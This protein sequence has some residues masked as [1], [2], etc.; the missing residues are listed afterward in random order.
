[1]SKE[2]SNGE[3]SV[4]KLQLLRAGSLRLAVIADEIAAITEWM[5]P[6][7][8]PNAPPA[9]LGVAS[10]QG[11]ML[12]V[13]DPLVLFKEEQKSSPAHIVAL[14]GDEQLALAVGSIEAQ[15]KFNLEDIQKPENTSNAVMGTL[16]H[17]SEQTYL[18]DVTQLFALSIRS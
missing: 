16:V 8:L 11:R 1:M 15:L 5:D 6:V 10:V 14:R 9:I 3:E 2:S 17:D 13:I 7:P 12:T 4:L 18:I